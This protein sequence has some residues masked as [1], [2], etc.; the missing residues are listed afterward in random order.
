MQEY[1]NFYNYTARAVKEANPALTVGGPATSRMSN[2][3]EF[4]GNATASGAPVDIITTHSVCLF[5]LVYRDG[6]CSHTPRGIWAVP[7][8]L[9]GERYTL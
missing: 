2:I 8:R 1:F 6:S 5:V 4:W 7:L 9:Q 3:P